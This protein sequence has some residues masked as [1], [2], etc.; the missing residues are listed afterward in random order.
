MTAN[1]TL[2]AYT[3][4]TEILFETYGIVPGTIRSVKVVNNG[5]ELEPYRASSIDLPHYIDAR[6]DPELLEVAERLQGDVMNREKLIRYI[7]AFGSVGGGLSNFKRLRRI[8]LSK[9][10]EELESMYSKLEAQYS[11]DKPNITKYLID[12]LFASLP[13]MPTDY[14]EQ[15]VK[16]AKELGLG[17]DGIIDLAIKI[18]DAEFRTSLLNVAS[19]KTENEKPEETSEYTEIPLEELLN[20]Y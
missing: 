11:G 6:D 7:W 16:R 10:I 8:L 12:H 13:N 2:S 17:D 15:E 18:S 19:E 3:K 1:D 4:F 14:L 9:P 20:E 5:I